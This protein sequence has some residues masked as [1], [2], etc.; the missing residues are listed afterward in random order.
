[1]HNIKKNQLNKYGNFR[2]VNRYTYILDFYI[3]DIDPGT[4]GSSLMTGTEIAF[5]LDKP[6]EQNYQALKARIGKGI[7]NP[8]LYLA[9]NKW[10]N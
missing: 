1:M 10:L 2:K 7:S 4:R 3:S 8:T 5:L 9:E 6:A